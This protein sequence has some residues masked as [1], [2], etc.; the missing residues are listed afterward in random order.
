MVNHTRLEAGVEADDGVGED[1]PLTQVPVPV[2]VP[3][4]APLSVP[5]SVPR[6]V[7]AIKRPRHPDAEGDEAEEDDVDIRLHMRAPTDVEMGALVALVGGAVAATYQ[8]HTD[9]F[10]YQMH[11]SLTLRSGST[12]RNQ[13]VFSN[14]WRIPIVVWPQTCMTTS[15][16]RCCVPFVAASLWW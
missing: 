5:A 7:P 11:F 2:P 13:R 10:H 1:V 15:C 9:L 8:V 6:R 12:Q 3:V 4:V 16:G 14:W